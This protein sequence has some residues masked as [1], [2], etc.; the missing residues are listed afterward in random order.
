MLQVSIIRIVSRNKCSGLHITFVSYFLWVNI[1]GSHGRDYEKGLPKSEAEWPDTD[2][3]EGSATVST[4]THDRG[5]CPHNKGYIFI[6]NN[7]QML[8][9][10]TYHEPVPFLGALPKLQKLLASPNLSVRPSLHTELGSNW[11]D[12]RE[13]WFLSIFRKSV[14]KIQ[15]S[16]KSKKNSGYF[17]WRRIH[18][19]IISRSFLLRIKNISEK[20]MYR[21]SKHT[22]LSNHFFK[23]CRL[24]VNVK[25]SVQPDRPQIT[26]WFMRSACWITKA[27]NTHS[28]YVIPVSFPLQQWLHESASM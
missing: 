18:F 22:F 20:K 26:T 4:K 10:I 19:F 24:W 1:W 12:F 6:R 7:A 2:T 14:Q 27:I 3:S 21:K 25:N 9:G 28:E 13:I 8:I 5:I 11:S 17:T 15:V 23:S 16:L